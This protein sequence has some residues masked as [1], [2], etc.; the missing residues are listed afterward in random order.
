MYKSLTK[1]RLKQLTKAAALVVKNIVEL[2][3]GEVPMEAM[4]P[5]LEDLLEEWIEEVDSELELKWKIEND[6]FNKI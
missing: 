3:L 5:E 4:V 1:K 2:E 6:G